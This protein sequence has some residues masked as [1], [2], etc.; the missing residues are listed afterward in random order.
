MSF[1]VGIFSTY[2][3]CQKVV[4]QVEVYLRPTLILYHYH[5]FLRFPD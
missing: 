2:C 4:Y 1:L 5:F 3:I